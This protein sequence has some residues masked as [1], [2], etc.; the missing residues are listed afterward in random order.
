M[1]GARRRKRED[2]TALVLKVTREFLHA[3]GIERTVT[4]ESRLSQVELGLD[5]I[6]C[7][8]LIAE[9]ERQGAMTIPERFWESTSTLT[10]GGLVDLVVK[11]GKR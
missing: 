7:L 2:A 6:A 11:R 9:V 1:F 5:S 10:L 3:R 8:E 4:I